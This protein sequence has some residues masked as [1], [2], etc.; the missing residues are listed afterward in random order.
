[1][2]R[3]GSQMPALQQVL[4]D[5]PPRP[6]SSAEVWL[7]D[8]LEGIAEFNRVLQ[9]ELP[10]GGGPAEIFGLSLPVLRRLADFQ[11]IS[12]W[13]PDDEGLLFD[14]VSVDP[15]AKRSVI[16]AELGH[17]VQA[18]QFAWAL[19]QSRGV[20][21][22]AADG[23]HWTLLHTLLA[24]DQVVGMLIAVLDHPV[25]GQP[26]VGLKVL[27]ILLQNWASAIGTGGL[28][29]ELDRRARSLEAD[30]E[31]QT[32]ELRRSEESA[33]RANSA[34][35]EFLA[36][37]SHEIRSPLG[38]ILGTAGLLLEAPLAPEERGRAE[39]IYRSTGL[40]LEIVNEILDLARIE[41]GHVELS[42]SDFDLQA[43]FEDVMAL[44]GPKAAE[45]AI[46]FEL[47]W[48]DTAPRFVHGDPLR[49][50]QIV[51]NVCSNAIKFTVQGAVRIR[52]ASGA[53]EGLVEITVK[54]SGVGV[55]HDRLES[56]FDKFEQASVQ[57][58]HNFGGTG[59]GLPISRELAHL[60]GG[61]IRAASDP[62]FGSTFTV[63]LPLPTVTGAGIGEL[64]TESRP[65]EVRLDGLRVLLADDDPIARGIASVYLGRLGCDVRTVENG[66]QAVDATLED[67]PHVILMDGNMPEMDGYDAAEAIRRR[68]GNVAPPIIALTAGGMESD[69]ARGEAAGMIMH[70]TKPLS[71]AELSEALSAVVGSMGDADETHEEAPVERLAVV[72]RVVREERFGGDEELLAR[73][74]QVF[75]DS[76]PA[77]LAQFEEAFAVGDGDALARVAHRTRGAVSTLGLLCLSEL[78]LELE[79]EWKSGNLDRA[80]WAFRAISKA[81]DSLEV[82]PVAAGVV[83]MVRW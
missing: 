25:L 26:D 61:S 56:I 27:S 73:L 59:L 35:D 46:G 76:W 15:P 33:R 62:G 30:I 2:R 51:M 28:N 79:L 67:R 65:R 22:Q 10:K 21:V 14:L 34:K 64:E 54:D 38:G 29:R 75:L 74:T 48:D 5:S 4:P 6:P 42:T 83:E 77:S 7:V 53:S 45:K 41:S 1:M 39:T 40:A 23:E 36:R 20:I 57:T 60:M 8:A 11:A 80:E 18:G 69:R 43:Q 71:Q 32:G 55:P 58:A 3:S 12:L 49:L 70:L 13:R 82:G 63:V 37:I 72:D 52:V 47:Q 19:Y 66:V 44:L 78:L 81:V 50:R 17:Q 31:R 9:T 68:L 24:G 16:E